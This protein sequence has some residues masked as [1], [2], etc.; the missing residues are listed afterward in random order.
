MEGKEEMTSKTDS[1]TQKKRTIDVKNSEISPMW[2]QKGQGK[3]ELT[4]EMNSV[5]LAISILKIRLL[6]SSY[7]KAPPM[8]IK[9]KFQKSVLSPTRTSPPVRYGLKL[10]DFAQILQIFF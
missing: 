5:T 6:Y 9:L 1:A 8:T 7:G 2:S 4:P 10:S 3:V